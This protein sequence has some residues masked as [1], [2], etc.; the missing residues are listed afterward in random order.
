M[1]EILFDPFETY[2]TFHC[3]KKHLSEKKFSYHDGIVHAG[4]RTRF[5][6]HWN[7]KP[8]VHHAFMSL[9]R[10]FKR[11][12]EMQ[13]HLLSVMVT[14]SPNIDR[15]AL[16]DLECYQ[17]WVGRLHAMHVKFGDDLML[18]RRKAGSLKKAIRSTDGQP[19]LYSMLMSGQISMETFAWLVHFQPRILDVM[20]ESFDP[21]DLAWKEKRMIALKY[22][23]F[24]TRLNINQ[25]RLKTILR[26]YVA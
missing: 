3:L 23:A 11:V 2:Y 17:R 25:E 4:L 18:L 5:R 26:G 22:P 15:G 9:T 7:S 8:M 6:K 1:S 20:D 14:R 12:E 24:L 10:K 16:Y 19:P 13:D 21:L